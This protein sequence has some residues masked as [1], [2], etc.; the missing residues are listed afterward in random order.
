V[1]EDRD[2]APIDAIMIAPNDATDTWR[3]FDITTLVRQ[4][5][6]NPETNCGILLAQAE[7]ATGAVQFISSQ[8]FKARR[9]GYCGGRRVAFRPMLVLR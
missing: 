3:A 4:W 7:P 6:A 8:A 5:A 9:D 2:E 1:P